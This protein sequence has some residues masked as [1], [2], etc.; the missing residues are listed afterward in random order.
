MNIHETIDKLAALPFEQQV[1]VLDFIEFLGARRRPA[2]V[3]ATPALGLDVPLATKN[4]PDGAFAPSAAF[5]PATADSCRRLAT[6][7]RPTC[8]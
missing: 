3:S 1:E 5:S 4:A 6:W 8:F 2:T 7:P